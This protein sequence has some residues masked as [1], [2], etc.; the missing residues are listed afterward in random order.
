MDALKLAVTYWPLVLGAAAFLAWTAGM[1][2]RIATDVAE[3]HSKMDHHGET[4]TEH[5]GLIGG[6]RVDVDALKLGAAR[7]SGEWRATRRQSDVVDTPAVD[8]PRA[9]GAAVRLGVKV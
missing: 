8:A 1:L 7:H 5:K 3:V 2:W 4:L 9:P 6:L